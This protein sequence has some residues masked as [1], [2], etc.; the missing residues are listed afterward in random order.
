MYQCSSLV[1]SGLVS[2]CHSC[3]SFLLLL[4]HNIVKLFLTRR[5][6]L[7]WRRPLPLLRKLNAMA[8]RKVE[9]FYFVHK[10]G[11]SSVKVGNEPGHRLLSFPHRE[12]ED[13]FSVFCASSRRR[14]VKRKSIAKGMNCESFVERF[15]PNFYGDLYSRNENRVKCLRFSSNDCGIADSICN[16]LE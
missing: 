10:G 4:F 5:R 16:I 8:R 15:L 3:R 6:R 12:R 9:L 14:C 11:A 2:S 13:L 7:K 1:Q